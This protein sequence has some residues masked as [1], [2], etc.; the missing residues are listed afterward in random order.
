MVATYPPI[1]R[2]TAQLRPGQ[3]WSIPLSD[4]R[5][6]CGRVLRVEHGRTWFVGAI[7]D[8]VG[9]EPPTSDAIAGSPVLE[10]GKAHIRLITFGDGAILGERPL[11]A[12]GIR[13][14]ATVDGY[15]GDGY[16]VVRAERRFIAGDPMPT[17]EFRQVSS[18]LTAEML[19]PSITGRGLVQF[20]RRL[21]D[22]DFRQLGEW[23]RPYPEMT[24]RA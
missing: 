8:W 14:P 13:A 6:G 2:A 20:D 21:T 24:L 11:S 17:E 18:P 10:V 16:G 12:D 3:Y 9:A 23:L 4:G 7:L 19:R 15:W 22:D 1:P 5:F